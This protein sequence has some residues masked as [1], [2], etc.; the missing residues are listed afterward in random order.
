VDHYRVCE[1]L[2][3]AVRVV[4]AHRGEPYSPAYIQGIS[5]AAFRIGGICPCAPTCSAAMSTQDLLK[6]LGYEFEEATLSGEGIDPARDVPKVVERVKDAVRAGRAVLV[7]HAFTNAEWDVVS[8]FDD[9]K[10]EFIGFGSYTA[11]HPDVWRA[12]QARMAKAVE[13][14]PAYGALIVGERTGEFNAR[15]AELGALEEAVRHCHAPRDEALENAGDKELPWKFREGKA[16]YDAWVH[17][18]RVD[19]SK[20]PEAGDRYCLGIYRSTRRMA[21]EFLREI[22]PRYPEAKG[23]FG[24]AAD[25]FDEEA[26]ALDR[27]CDKLCEGWEGW[28]EPDPEKAER[29]AEALQVARKRYGAAVK[30]VEQGLQETDPERVERAHREAEQ[31]QGAQGATE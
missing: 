26:D 2:F 21:A 7:W 8:G 5:G 16:C 15:E 6:L 12:P 17:G 22:A 24:K 9:E 27:C 29:M 30:E 31:K 1:P 25:L 20:V 10:G 23:H 3:E 18:Y 19:P 28:K 11:G 4:L 14:C 13:I